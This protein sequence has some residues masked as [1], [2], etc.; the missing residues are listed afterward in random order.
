MANDLDRLTYRKTSIFSMVNS[1]DGYDDDE[2]ERS[3]WHSF[4]VGSKV[5]TENLH[6]RLDPKANSRTPSM[7]LLNDLD[8]AVLGL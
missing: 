4:Q 5:W 6:S 1:P 7:H 2:I 8:K 3:H